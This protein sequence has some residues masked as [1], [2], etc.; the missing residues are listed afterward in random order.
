MRV[1]IRNVG[2]LFYFTFEKFPHNKNNNN[3][4]NQQKKKSKKNAKKKK[5][6]LH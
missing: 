2:S 1:R 5:F 3:E 4:N 6:I